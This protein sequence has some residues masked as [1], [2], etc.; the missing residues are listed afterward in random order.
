[1]RGVFPAQAVCGIGR[2]S[3]ETKPPF[4]IMLAQLWKITTDHEGESTVTFKVP[5]SELADVVKLNLL[6]QKELEIT[7][8]QKDEYHNTF[9][10]GESS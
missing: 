8:R 9:K 4:L 3:N 2:P 10:T 1:M 5:F 6:L 7:I